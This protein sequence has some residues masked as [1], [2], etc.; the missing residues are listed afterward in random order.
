VTG[1]HP[2][3]DG[4]R[5]V[6]VLMVVVQHTMGRMPIDLGGVSDPVEAAIVE[7]AL[8]NQSDGYRMVCAFVRRRLGVANEPQAASALDSASS[9]S[10]IAAA[11]AASPSRRPDAVSQP[12]VA[13]RIT[14][15]ARRRGRRSRC[16]LVG[17]R[18]RGDL[19]R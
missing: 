9:G 1:Y 18:R 7:E 14:R 16:F 8:A 5:A 19:G 17:C 13:A 2:W 3:L 12:V 4:L 10:S 11:A 15:I 6:A